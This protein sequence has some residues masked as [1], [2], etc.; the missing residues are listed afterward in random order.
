MAELQ[1]PLTPRLRARTDQLLAQLQRESHWHGELPVL[2]LDRCWLR[3]QEVPVRRLAQVLPPDASA[4]APELVLYRQLRR[5]GLS[6]LEAQD[7]CWQEFG[8][9]A[10]TAALQ[11]FW[12]MQER[13]NNGW[14]LSTYLELL[15]RYRRQLEQGGDTPLPLL[16]LARN[17]GADDHELLWCWP[18]P[19]VMRHTCR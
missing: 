10:C 17:D 2:L 18:Q 3:L 7:L 6:Q 13:G 14:T 9:N 11:R 19:P 5:S 12:Q 8:R 15:S 4:E 16:M 1:S